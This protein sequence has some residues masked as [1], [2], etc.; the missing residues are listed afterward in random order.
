MI[1]G[2][3][4]EGLPAAVLA[5]LS[6]PALKTTETEPFFAQNAPYCA[7]LA[8]VYCGDIKSDIAVTVIIDLSKPRFAFAPLHQ[9]D[10]PELHPMS[11]EKK[12]LLLLLR[13][14]SKR[15]VTK[16]IFYPLEK[17]AKMES[18]AIKMNMFGNIQITPKF[19]K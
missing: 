17:I 2:K 8:N 11:D 7:A 15:N 16:L 3:L 1:T 9:S 6:A 12:G 18:V 13:D 14:G 5:V 4:P 19:T 10:V